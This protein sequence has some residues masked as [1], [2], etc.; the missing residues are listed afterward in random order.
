MATMKDHGTDYSLEEDE[1]VQVIL[2]KNER[3]PSLPL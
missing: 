2:T 1:N 3:Q